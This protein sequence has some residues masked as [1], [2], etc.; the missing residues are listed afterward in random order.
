MCSQGVIHSRTYTQGIQIHPSLPYNIHWNNTSVTHWNERLNS[1]WTTFHLL[2]KQ[3]CGLFCITKSFQQAQAEGSSKFPVS[4][5]GRNQWS[6]SESCPLSL[7]LLG[8]VLEVHMA[9]N[10]ENA[11]KLPP[12]PLYSEATQQSKLILYL[13]LKCQ[14]CCHW[15]DWEWSLVLQG[16]GSWRHWQLH[17]R[18]ALR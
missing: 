17:Q 2:K 7:L 9:F 16:A 1:Q 18:P 6:F 11:D 12:L 3:G 10:S 14:Q 8:S 5:G 15:G 13:Q 4:Y